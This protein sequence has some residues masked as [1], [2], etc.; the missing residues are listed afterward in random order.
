MKIVE[1]KFGS[2]LYSLN[3]PQSDTDWKVL[4]MPPV[5]D[6]IF[7]AKHNIVESTGGQTKNTKNDTDTEYI[8]IQKF[9]KDA[10]AGQ[11]YAIDMLHCKEPTVSSDLW[12]Q[13]VSNRKKFYTKN[14]KA[15][16][17]Y[18]THQAAK[19]G[20][21]GSRLHSLS[22]AIDYLTDIDGSSIRLKDVEE[23]LYVDDHCKIVENTNPKTKV[24][25]KYYSVLGKMYQFTNS[26]DYVFECLRLTY[27]NYS[28]RAKDAMNNNNV[29]WK[30]ISH[31]LR[32]G[33]QLKHILVDGDFEYPLPESEFILKVKK[34]ELTFDEVS[35]IL[36]DLVDE[37]TAL[38][39][40]SE[41]PL[42]P[43]AEFFYTLIYDAY[44]V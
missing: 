28:Q 10:L 34:G 5:R 12:E 21:K 40:K 18:C 31:A 42:E 13:I 29:D 41:L 36:S 24:T 43:D 1:M 25:E 32:A 4:F 9:I 22:Q 3:T 7:G 16:L 8:S 38:S 20:I 17:G 27:D 26:A 44:G 37:V 2:H 35:P 14:M 19:Y 15:Y 11:T 6:L 23:F 33:Y 39:I 30:A